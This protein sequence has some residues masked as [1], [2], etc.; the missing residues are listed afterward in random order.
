MRTSIHI[1]DKLIQE[2]QKVTS[3][4]TKK[5]LIDLSLKELV[6]RK[7]LEHLISLYGTNPIDLTLK[8]LEES[9]ED[10]I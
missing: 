6:R 9:R 2:A 3:V 4:K 7:R 1:D 10:E 5:A 8:E